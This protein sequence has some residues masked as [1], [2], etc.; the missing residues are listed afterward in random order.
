MSRA[1][2]VRVGNFH[3]DKRHMS[4]AIL[5]FVVCFSAAF[6]SSAL[7]TFDDYAALLAAVR[8]GAAMRRFYFFEVIVPLA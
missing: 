3:C 4:L 5:H 7:G 8:R 2:A 6:K 1:K